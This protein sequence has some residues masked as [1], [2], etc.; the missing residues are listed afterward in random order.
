[1]NTKVTLGLCVK[2]AA[3]IVKTAFHS[4]SIQDYPHELMKLVIVDNGSIDNTLSVAMRF[5]Q[6]TDIPTLVASNKGKGLGA[7]RQIAADNAE[8]DYII[9]VDDDLV[10]TTDYVRNQVEFME[11]NLQIGAAQGTRSARW[12]GNT[13]SILEFAS[14][15]LS[16][17]TLKQ[18]GTGGS[19]F[20]LKALGQA[21]GFDV[22]I[23]G[24]GEDL[25]VSRKLR[26]SGW[27]LAI[28]N[29]AR[30][31]EKYSPST[32]KAFWKRNFSYGYEN[33]YFFHKYEDRQ[34]LFKYFPIFALYVGLIISNRIYRATNMKKMFFY[35]VLYFLC[36]IIGSLGFARAHLD[37]YGHTKVF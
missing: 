19:I 9:W 3:T 11:R 4:I 7:S 29:S 25:D 26:E 18:I 27:A 12:D 22:R 34:Y 35:V 24:A 36:M 1:M 6:E 20:R 2:N 31:Y 16:Q 21:G 5:A 8:G 28:N 14:L 17:Q 33:H 30:Y 32:L 15:T 13:Y 23:K 37:A 10:L